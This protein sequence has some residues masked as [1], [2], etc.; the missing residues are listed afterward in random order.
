MADSF[1][2]LDK[3]AS[4]AEL[5]YA[6]NLGVISTIGNTP[7]TDITGVTITFPVGSTPVFVEAVCEWVS[8]QTAGVTAVILI[9]DDNSNQK[10]QSLQTMPTVGK[11]FPLRTVERITT[12]GTYTRKLSVYTTAAVSGNCT[13]GFGV[14]PAPKAYIRAIQN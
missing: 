14:T 9:R 6:E 12:P 1:N 4:G 2:T 10:A 5:A 7:I 3:P 11:T 13:V 8:V